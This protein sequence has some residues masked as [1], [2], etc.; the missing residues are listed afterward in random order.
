[1]WLRDFLPDLIPTARI[2]TYSYESDWRRVDVKTNLRECGEQLLNVLRQNRSTEKEGRRPLVFIGHSLGGLVIKQVGVVLARIDPVLSSPQ[3][4]VL[5]DHGDT[6]RDI[7]LS[8]A[9]IIFL[10]TPHQGSDAAMYG[11]W[12]AHAAGYDKTLLESLKRNSPAL[13]NIARDFEA[14]YSNADIVC[15]YEDKDVSYGPL[16]TQFVNH[17]SA[18]LLGKREIY[19]STDHSGLNK[20]RSSD[21]ENFLL[22]RPEI[23]R[24]VQKAPQRIEEQYRSHA[25]GTEKAQGPQDRREDQETLLRQTLASDYKSDKDL[26]SERVPGTCEWFFE[27]DRFLEWRDS[28]I[29]KLL[30]V[31]AGPG[32]GKSVLAR[33]LIDERSLCTNTTAP[34]VC[35]FFFK[36]GQ[37]QRTR[38]ANALCAL[39]HQLFESTRLITHALPS[40]KSYRKKLRD[41][42][43]ELWEILVKSAQDS[44]AGEIICVLDALDECEKNARNQLIDKLVHFFSQAESCQNTSIQLKFLVTS[45]PY[46]DLEQ[47][48]R[49]LSGVS[50]YM[51][52]DGD[53][54][55][56]RIG[57]DINLVIDA[58]IPYITGDFK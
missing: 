38:G 44:E 50:T 17:Q 11:G 2:A 13:H 33:A 25:V 48:F 16:K 55:S 36:D 1:M 18:T 21:D 14:S 34:T 24:M 56:Q 15:F 6:F 5:A 53:E 49:R 35:Y 22:V 10:G 23:Q 41:A 19:L 12:L 45:R 58:K 20:F 27:D 9:G 32:C 47:N 8:T 54:K 26:V 37:K 28:N 46:D 39:L 30:W 3:A 57:Q 51:R 7:R 29:S 52:F 4:L 31:S 40:Y 43:S 42:F